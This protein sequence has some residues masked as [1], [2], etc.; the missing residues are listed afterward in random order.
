[1]S[2]TKEMLFNKYLRERIIN[3]DFYFY[4]F[5]KCKTRIIEKFDYFF[6]GGGQGEG[7]GKGS[8]VDSI[9]NLYLTQATEHLEAHVFS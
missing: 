9:H 8:D 4:S 6:G 2:W 1:M 3:L 5:F 7:G